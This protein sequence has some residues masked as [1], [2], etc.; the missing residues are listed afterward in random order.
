MITKEEALLNKEKVC[1]AAVQSFFFND[2]RGLFEE[3]TGVGKTKQALDI[4]KILQQENPTIGFR[5]LI[6]VPTTVLRD[7]DWPEEC[8]KWGIDTTGMKIICG[9]SLPKED[10]YVYDFFILDEFHNISYLSLLRLQ[11][12]MG[13]TRTPILALSASIP[14]TFMSDEQHLKYMLVNELFPIIYRVSVDEAVSKGLVKDFEIKVLQMELDSVTRNVKA[15]PPTKLFWTTEQSNYDYLSKAI[16]EE[17]DDTRKNMLVLRRTKFLYNLPSKQK[18]AKKVIERFRS[19]RKRFL[20]FGG[21]IDGIIELG[22]L[23]QCHQSRKSTKALENFQS[24]E[25]SELYAVHSIDEG[26]N[27]NKPDAA[28]IQQCL[29]DPRYMIQRLGRV[30][31]VDYENMDS[32]ALIVVLEVS[33]TPDAEW[34]MNSLKYFSVKRI[35]FYKHAI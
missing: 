10:L 8:I 32:K 18:V 15:G 16:T 3:C 13:N 19:L 7:K 1:E 4:L 33:G 25:S 14:K 5:T 20:V 12:M 9:D 6:V 2:R 28:L 27:L 26:V 31:R 29:L 24:G 21:S 34:V 30:I 35:Q 23:E 22:G 17:K 11:E